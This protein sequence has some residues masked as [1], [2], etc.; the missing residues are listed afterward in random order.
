MLMFF[1]MISA[2]DENDNNNLTT[3]TF[4]KAQ[5]KHESYAEYPRKGHEFS[6]KAKN[7]RNSTLAIT[8][9][10][11]AADPAL[12][13]SLGKKGLLRFFGKSQSA[14]NV[15]SIKNQPTKQ[16]EKPKI[17]SKTSSKILPTKINYEEE[18]AINI[19]EAF[20]DLPAQP[21]EIS[22]I[23]FFGYQ[24]RACTIQNITETLKKYNRTLSDTDVQQIA[25]YIH[26][27]NQMSKLP[28]V[29]QNNTH[30][31][32]ISFLEMSFKNGWETLKMVK[33]P[34]LKPAANQ[35]IEV[36]RGQTYSLAPRNVRISNQL[37]S[38]IQNFEK[39]QKLN[40]LKQQ[41]RRAISKLDSESIRNLISDAEN[42]GKSNKK[43]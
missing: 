25:F 43:A 19:L 31:C 17:T 32:L 27:Y 36:F 20:N 4:K 40:T 24:A 39:Y 28:S 8:Q 34:L 1:C 9:T 11:R 37:K 38:E 7:R 21:Y 14:E 22:T 23:A 26:G 18:W 13:V 30:F 29:L 35:A 10:P 12:K 16:S 6:L 2:F 41:N 3:F 5:T 42:F 15:L 33:H